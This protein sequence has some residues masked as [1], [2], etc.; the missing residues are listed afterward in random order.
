MFVT[1]Y[2]VFGMPTW[3]VLVTSKPSEEHNVYLALT[4]MKEVEYIYPLFGEWD[5]L[6]KIKHDDEEQLK[7]FI[8]DRVKN[9]SGLLTMKTLIGL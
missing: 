7:K 4:R 6:F 2:M 9:I 3:Y 8:I 5:I 1:C